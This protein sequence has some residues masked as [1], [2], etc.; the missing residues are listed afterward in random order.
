MFLRTSLVFFLFS[1]SPNFLFRLIFTRETVPWR[2]RKYTFTPGELKRE[3]WKSRIWLHQKCPAY[4]ERCQWS[5][6]SWERCS[7]WNL[8]V[9][10]STGLCGWVSV[11]IKWFP[12][13]CGGDKCRV[14]Q[15]V[16]VRHYFL[17]TSCFKVQP[18]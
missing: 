1:L 18:L 16:P 12:S 7:A 4:S 8:K 14:G 6:S 3:R 2:L 11:S 9:C 10:R 13:K 17:L 5:S 15:M